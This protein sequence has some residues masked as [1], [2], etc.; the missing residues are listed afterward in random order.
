MICWK[1]G[2]EIEEP[3]EGKIGFRMQCEVC[4]SWQ[5]ACINCA[6]YKHGMPNDCTIPDTEPVYDREKNNF[7]E[8]FSL[9]TAEARP[10]TDISDVAATLF[11]NQGPAEEPSSFNDLFEDK[12]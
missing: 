6:Y 8:E 1:C 12:R 11:G 3:P 2:E 10:H 9:A 4:G 5:H 7:C